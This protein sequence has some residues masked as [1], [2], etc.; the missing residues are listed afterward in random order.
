MHPDGLDALAALGGGQV[1]AA[2]V[3]PHRQVRR[4]EDILGGG[5]V[6][7]E[8]D[9][10]GQDSRGTRDVRALGQERRK[11]ELRGHGVVVSS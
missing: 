2:A 11:G 10:G 8:A 1:H 9:H 3:A 5:S 6:F 4:C 7:L